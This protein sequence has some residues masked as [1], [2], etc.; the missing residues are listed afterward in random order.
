MQLAV[1]SFDMWIFQC[2]GWKYLVISKILLMEEIQRSPVE[3][4]STI[5]FGQMIPTY[6]QIMSQR[7]STTYASPLRPNHE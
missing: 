4:G 5:E 3:V 7:N 2:I 1:H 6:S